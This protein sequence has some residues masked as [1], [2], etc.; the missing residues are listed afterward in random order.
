MRE[1]WQDLRGKRTRQSSLNGQA[2]HQDGHED[3][4]GHGVDHASDDGLEVPSPSDPSIDQIGDAGVGEEADC[5]GMLIMQNEIG[6][7]GG[8]D[9][10]GEGEDVG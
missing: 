8:G 4:V 9:E 6:D 10:A 1:G 5:P 3:L 7:D 2:N